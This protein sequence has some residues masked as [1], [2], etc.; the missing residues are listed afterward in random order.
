[1]I[2][3]ERQEAL[4]R[5]GPGTPAGE[6]LRRYWHPVAATSELA[7]GSIKKVRLL[8]EDLALYRDLN[9]RPGLIDEACPHRRA[10]MAHGCAEEDGLRCPYHGWKFDHTGACL[11]MPPEPA[12]SKLK[13]RVRTPAYPVEELGGLIFAYLGPA[14]APL[15]PRYDLLVWEGVLRD[16]GQAMLPCNWL[17]IMENSVDPHHTEWLHG[18]HLSHVQRQKGEERKLAYRKRHEKIG[19]DLFPHGIIKRRVLEGGSDDDDNWKIGHPLI[20]PTTL[21]VGE[22]G[23]HRLQI[24]VPV[25]DT[26]TWHLWYSC[27][28]FEDEIDVPA[29]ET[30]PLYDVPWKDEQD[31]F[32]TDFVDGGDIMVWVTQ[33]PIADRTRENLGSSDKG[34]AMYRRL[35]L[36]EMAKVRAGED[37]LGVIRDHNTNGIIEL[38]QERDKFGG[39]AEF[40]IQ[41]L[42]NGHARHSPLKDQVRR[43]LQ[44]ASG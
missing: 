17:Q 34:I 31:R 28:R 10:S 20:F 21:C 11:E 26:H 36:D 13:T 8:C 23:R 2:D 24:R 16:I 42:E 22:Q 14:P 40:L 30:V 7:P 44:N 12:K 27:Y 18:H 4:T 37:P 35:L 39:G 25:D 9:G 38:P 3:G 5:V 41:A 19:F 15:L 43:L 6:L 32:I 29:Q 1:M 33:G